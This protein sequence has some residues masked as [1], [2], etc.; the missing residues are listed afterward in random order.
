MGKILGLIAGVALTAV[1]VLAGRRRHEHRDT[2]PRMALSR[3]RQRF[4]WERG[5]LLGSGAVITGVAV[6]AAITV[7]GR[8]RGGWPVLAGYALATASDQRV[9]ILLWVALSGSAIPGPFRRISLGTAQLALLLASQG[10]HV[11]LRGVSGFRGSRLTVPLLALSTVAGLSCI[12]GALFYDPSVPGPPRSVGVQLFAT[13]L[14]ELSIAAA[15][16]VADSIDGVATVRL[17]RRALLAAGMPLMIASWSP[18][19]AVGRPAWWRLTV[20]HSIAQVY[21]SIFFDSRQSRWMKCLAVGAVGAA[22]VELVLRDLLR[23]CFDQWLS[24]WLAVG[25]AILTITFLRS[26]RVF[27]GL[28]LPL[29]AAASWCARRPLKRVLAMAVVKRDFDRLLIWRDAFR[30]AA[31]RPLFGVGPG[32]YPEYAVRYAE[33]YLS[34]KEPFPVMSA[35]FS[36]PHGN[37]P[38]LAAEIGFTGLATAGW[39]LVRALGL[40]S[41]LLRQ[42]DEPVLRSFV[43]GATGSIAGQMVAS[44]LGDYIIPAYQNAGATNLGTSVYTWILMGALMGIDRAR[45]PAPFRVDSWG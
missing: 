34:A 6:A 10:P 35:T 33:S 29:C 23:P 7:A 3:S 2:A 5:L 19:N 24:G 1:V 36:S 4:P 44:T 9:G 41:D 28:A 22:L 37:Y 38:Q 27:F 16:L 18:V 20:V 42:L 17:V 15:F 31:R 25:S 11:A 8:R 32:N 26:P 45:E 30:L 14:V 39:V 43:A 40:G 13:A 12:Q 21:A